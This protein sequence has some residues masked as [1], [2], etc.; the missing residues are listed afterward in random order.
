MNVEK[1][2]EKQREKER[3]GEANKNS[4]ETK[5]PNSVG[6]V[7]VRLFTWS[8]LLFLRRRKKG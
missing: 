5:F 4:A 6:M 8:S 2:K 7:P 1:K 3:E